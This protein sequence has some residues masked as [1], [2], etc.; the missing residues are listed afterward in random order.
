MENLCGTTSSF[1]CQTLTDEQIAKKVREKY[2]KVLDICA[3]KA[4]SSGDGWRSHQNPSGC[5]SN[6]QLWI[7]G[8]CLGHASTSETD[9]D[10]RKRIDQKK[11]MRDAVVHQHRSQGGR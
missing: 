9:A 11:R 5:A 1:W 3:E 4:I 8:D 2:E 6:A 7:L 10:L